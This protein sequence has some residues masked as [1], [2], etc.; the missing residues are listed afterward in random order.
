MSTVLTLMESKLWNIHSA[1][2]KCQPFVFRCENALHF[3]RHIGTI[4]GTVLTH[5]E[6]KLFGIDN[7]VPKCSPFVNSL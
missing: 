1:V 4:M 7:A 2:I 6:S 3:C 5:V